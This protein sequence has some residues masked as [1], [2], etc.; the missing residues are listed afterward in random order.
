MG[1]KPPGKSQRPAKKEKQPFR[2]QKQLGQHWLVDQSVVQAI[3]SATL[4]DDPAVILEIGPGQ[5]VLTQALAEKIAETDTQLLAIE[6]DKR[7]VR[8]LTEQFADCSNVHIAHGDILSLT[9]ERFIELFPGL[10]GQLPDK[11]AVVGNLPYQIT[12][13]IIRHFIGDLASNTHHEWRQRLQHLTIMV[14]QEVAHRILAEP[15]TKA[16]S[17]L[18]LATQQ[19]ATVD[20]VCPNVFPKAFRPPPKVTSAVVQLTPRLQPLLPN[21]LG[22]PLQ[23]V[24]EA[25]FRQRRKTLRNSLGALIPKD[26]LPELFAWAVNNNDDSPLTADQLASAR[27]ETLAL[28]MFGCL[29][30]GAIE[31]G[32]LKPPATSRKTP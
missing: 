9:P 17:L 25:A 26:K 28:S 32:L 30:T 22:A 15:A 21:V 1:N 11:L 7:A 10:N 13:R 29:T 3:V 31:L 8:H 27:P 18:T 20:W 5:G 24:V 6:L 2:A 4:T 14:Q 23:R 12:N 19:F 16:Y